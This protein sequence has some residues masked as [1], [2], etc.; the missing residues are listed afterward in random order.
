MMRRTPGT[1]SE[2]LALLR[3]VDE[4]SLPHLIADVLPCR[5]SFV[6]QMTT[7]RFA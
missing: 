5:S 2:K 1:P 6:A 4:T 7:D 3:G